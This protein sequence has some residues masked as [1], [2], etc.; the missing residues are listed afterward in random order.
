MDLKVE[1]IP[2]EDIKPYENNAKLHPAFQIE[3]IKKSIQEFGFADP[4][5]LWHGEIVEGHGRYIAAQK[6]GMKVIPCIKLDALTDEQRRAYGLIHN[7]LTMNSDFDIDLLAEELDSIGDIDMGDFGFSLDDIGEEPQ[8]VQEDNFDEEPPEE[9]TSKLGDIY[10]LGEHRLMCGDST[11]PEHVA[12]LMDGAKAELTFTDPPYELKT[13]GGGVLKKANSM[14]QIRENGVD[15]FDPIKLN[16]YSKTNIYCHNKPLIKK[17]IELAEQNK[18]PYD[19]CF[20]KKI[21]TP[22]NYGGHMMTDC[23]YIAIIGNQSP[24]S[25]LEKELYSKCYV[26]SKDADNELSY[27]KPIGL[28]AKFIRLY[29]KENVLDLFGGS[30]STLMACEQLG[31][32]CY[33]MEMSPKYVDVIIKR[34]E[35]FTGRKAEKL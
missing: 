15:S 3:Q 21:S 2:I 5:A 9:P 18:Q 20:Y 11:N 28:C 16:L 27:S 10:Q 24:A 6:L 25:G 8:E 31:R 12:R 33:M 30:G 14:K 1:Y 26:G 32:K 13:K 7:K 29:S 17:Y 22:P 19:L 35:T 34:W 4:L 23:E